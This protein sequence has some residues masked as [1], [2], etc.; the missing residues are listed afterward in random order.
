MA[1]I[2][3]VLQLLFSALSL[4][5]LLDKALGPYITKD[6]ESSIQWFLGE[7][8]EGSPGQGIQRIASFHFP[9]EP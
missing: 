5:F 8:G 2:S 4:I 3:E 6:S 9:S 7:S 1:R